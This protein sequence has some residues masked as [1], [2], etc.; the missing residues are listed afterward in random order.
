MPLSKPY[1]DQINYIKNY[2]KSLNKSFTDNAISNKKIH[3]IIKKKTTLNINNSRSV[4][5]ISN[6]NYVL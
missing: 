4:R 5:N 2:D 6:Y 1:I 3:Y